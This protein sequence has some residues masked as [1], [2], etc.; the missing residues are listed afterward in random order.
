RCRPGWSAAQSGTSPMSFA[1]RQ[2]LQR[3]LARRE[4]AQFAVVRFVLRGFG[5]PEHD[6]FAAFLLDHGGEG[7]TL[8][9]RH[10]PRAAMR[11]LVVTHAGPLVR[12]HPPAATA[13]VEVQEPGQRRSRGAQ[14]KVSPRDQYG[15]VNAL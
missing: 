14:S 7:I 11:T 15:I 12:P 5:R 8:E 1:G 2:K 3:P 13:F 9:R 6:E 10:V 4:T